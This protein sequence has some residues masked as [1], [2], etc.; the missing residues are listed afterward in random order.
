MVSGLDN[1]YEDSTLWYYHSNFEDEGTVETD[2]FEIR[3]VVCVGCGNEV[4]DYVDVE[5]R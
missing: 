5:Q 2:D 4:T 3:R 1:D